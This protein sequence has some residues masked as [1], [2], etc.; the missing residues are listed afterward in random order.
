MKKVLVVEDDE[1][2]A[3]EYKRI[4]NKYNYEVK[5][6]S[7][8]QRA[9]NLID[10]FKPDLILLDILLTSG[11]AFDLIHELKSYDD[12]KKIPII[13]CSNLADEVNMQKLDSYGIKKV[14]NKSKLKAADL[15]KQIE[16]IL[17]EN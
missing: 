14:F 10:S 17:H 1:W 13:I 12:T 3:D 5:H 8:S 9:V 2:L 4:L 6:T 15:I 7:Y 11:S 16:V